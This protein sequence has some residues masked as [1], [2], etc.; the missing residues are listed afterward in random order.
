[1]NQPI[2]STFIPFPTSSAADPHAAG[3][4]TNTA[5][6]AHQTAH[7]AVATT[8]GTKPAEDSPGGGAKRGRPSGCTDRVVAMIKDQIRRHGF[9]DTKAAQAVGVSSTSISRWKKNDPELVSEPLKA[10]FDCRIYHLEIIENAAA[11]EN[12]R[13]WRA[14]AWMLERLFPGEYAPER[15][16]QADRYCVS[17]TYSLRLHHPPHRRNVRTTGSR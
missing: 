11:A 12:G 10:Q 3:A 16:E 15:A 1:M 14:S 13:G 8:G 2:D 9:S 6:G 7:R 4:Q 17:H 5:H